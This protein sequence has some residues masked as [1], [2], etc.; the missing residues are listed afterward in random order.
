MDQLSVNP[1]DNPEAVQEVDVWWG[2]YA[3]RTMLPGFVLTGVLTLGIG[4]VAG[5][6]WYIVGVPAQVARY[7]AYVL[8]VTVWLDRAFRLAY[9]S[10]SVT[11]RLTTRRLLRD[12]GFFRPADGQIEL[13]RVVDVRVEQG[14]LERLVGVGRLQIITDNAN[15]PMILAGVKEP[16]YI[17][18][19]I[20]GC[21]RQVKGGQG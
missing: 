1:A 19:K 10:I 3:S 2:G 20:R 21:V 13:T 4:A 14:G 5:L 18:S 7:G 6:L 11:Y 15:E 9:R 8:V 17:A 16:E 12:R